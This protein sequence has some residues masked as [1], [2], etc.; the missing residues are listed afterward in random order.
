[1]ARGRYAA[2]TVAKHFNIVP[3]L[4]DKWSIAS[5]DLSQPDVGATL[6]EVAL[7]PQPSFEGAET[8]ALSGFGLSA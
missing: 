1:M 6:I 7:S 8:V 3:N 2:L 4:S 5:L